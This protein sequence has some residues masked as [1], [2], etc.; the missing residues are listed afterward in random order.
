[1]QGFINRLVYF[2]GFLGPA[3]TVPQ[4]LEIWINKNT[5]GISLIMWMGYLLVAVTW[6][7][8]GIVNKQK[9]LIYIYIAWIVIDTTIL[10]G[11]TIL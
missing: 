9:P 3:I 10:V 1:M 11:L 4:V 2:T 6:L 5:Q 7:L 8:Y